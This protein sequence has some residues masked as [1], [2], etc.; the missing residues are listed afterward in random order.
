LPYNRGT[1]QAM[2]FSIKLYLAAEQPIVFGGWLEDVFG[3]YVLEGTAFAKAT[4]P[5]GPGFIVTNGP[6]FLSSG[7]PLVLGSRVDPGAFIA[8]GAA[9]G[10]AIPYGK[11]YCI[12]V[13]DTTS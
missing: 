13:P 4:G 2:P 8:A 11:L 5:S 7:A 1:D 3:K 12:F 10:E 9:D 6:M